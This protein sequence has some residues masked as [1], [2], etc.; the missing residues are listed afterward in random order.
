MIQQL[1]DE[2]YVM[3]SENL[4]CLAKLLLKENN[5][6]QWQSEYPNGYD[7][8]RDIDSKVAYGYFIDDQLVGY[9]AIQTQDD[10]NYA[11]IDGKWLTDGNYL[12]IHRICVDPSFAHQGIS[13]AMIDY[14]INKAKQKNCSVRIDTHK[15]NRAMQHV[16]RDCGFAYCGIIQLIYDGTYRLA[17]ELKVDR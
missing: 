3:P 12:T 13:K 1:T 5:I 14:V 7:A 8:K 9:M 10:P 6:D 11:T 4:F 17:Y 2:K 15:D 16:L